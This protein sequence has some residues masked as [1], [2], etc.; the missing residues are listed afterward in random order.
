M[1][2]LRALDER[3]RVAAGRLQITQQEV[4]AGSISAADVEAKGQNGPLLGTHLVQVTRLEGLQPA[5][6]DKL[7]GT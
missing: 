6:D 3:L 4:L 1:V 2:Q 7:I 5:R